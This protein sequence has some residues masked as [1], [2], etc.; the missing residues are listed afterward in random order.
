MLPPPR[1]APVSEDHIRGMLNFLVANPSNSD[2]VTIVINGKEVQFLRE[3]DPV[4][5]GGTSS[6]HFIVSGHSRENL[7][8]YTEF[9][10]FM[11]KYNLYL[12]DCMLTTSDIICGIW[13]T[14]C[15]RPFQALLL[16]TKKSNY[17]KCVLMKC[18][19]FRAAFP[20]AKLAPEVKFDADL[21]HR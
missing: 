9:G 7:Y 6:I 12:E 13:E 14:R 11:T 2:P 1:V 15:N 16:C 18:K 4:M 10:A 8:W 21:V 17:T 20:G 3:D 19:D 5:S